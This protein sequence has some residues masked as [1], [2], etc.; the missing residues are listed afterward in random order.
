MPDLAAGTAPTRV[1][2]VVLVLLALA[3]TCAYLTRIISAF[4][5]T[6]VAEFDISNEKVGLVTAGFALGYFVFQVPGGLLA[7]WFGVR[8]VLPLMGLLW[9]LFA[10]WGSQARSPDELYS[11]RIAL[12]V[13]QAGLVPCCAKVAADWF[14]LARRGLV[15]ALL[16]GGMQLGAVIATGL[17]ARLLGTVSWRDLLL[18]YA[19][20]GI[21]WALAFFLGF[22]NRPEEHPATNAAERAL[23]RE[24]RPPEPKPVGTALPSAGTHFRLQLPGPLGRILER[25]QVASPPQSPSLPAP[26][27]TLA[28]LGAE[29][30]AVA[31]SWVVLALTLVTNPSLWAYHVQ[32]F[33][34]AYGYAFF[35]SWFPAYLEKA[36]GVET[37]TAG[38]WATW[39]LVA[40]SL[41]TLLAG[42][43][44]DYLLAR[45]G[46]RWVSRSGSAIVGLG[47]C[48]GCFAL[49][50]QT[51]DPKLVVAVLSL[52]CLF[53]SLSGPAT[54]AAGMD[55]GGR[56]TAVLFGLMN[57]VGNIGAYLCPPRVGRMFDDVQQGSGDW[58]VILWLFA[59]VNAAGALT[60]VFVNPRRPVGE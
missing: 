24:G 60:W 10:V 54:W 37:A 52:G 16:A 19:V 56:Y 55:L 44:V 33:F 58:N 43:V 21:V 53:W 12:G 45:T 11:S 15:S 26:N 36:Y 25:Q 32:E 20:I 29:P 8:L 48:A 27:E 51:H 34:R 9:S 6:L 38:E 46:S 50:T 22:R 30:R 42:F 31:L 17:S 18:T 28:R 49:C 13:A 23:I 4:N 40:F 14:P 41:G 1:R 57:M 59:G 35:T 2:Y 47:A 7:G 3:P 5:T 39:P